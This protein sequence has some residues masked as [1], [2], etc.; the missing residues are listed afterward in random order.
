MTMMIDVDRGV[1]YGLGLLTV[2][3]T[4]QWKNKIQR[5]CTFPLYQYLTSY[6]VS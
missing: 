5:N 3:P 2:E 4:V 6:L 1:G